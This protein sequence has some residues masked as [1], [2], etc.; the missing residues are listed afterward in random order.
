MLSLMRKAL[1]YFAHPLMTVSPRDLLL[2]EHLHP[3]QT[4]TALEIGVGSGSSLFQLAERVA[5]LHGV[6]IAEGPV[7]RLRKAIERTSGA[8]RRI[9]LFVLDYCESGAAQKLPQRYD[10]IYSCD[11]VE[12]V[13]SPA[14]FFENLHHALRPGGRAF[15]AFPN[16]HPRSA[17]GITFFEHR[18]TLVDL[19]RR[20]GFANTSITI[21]TLQ[22]TPA[23]RRV[24]Q[25][26]WYRP[27][28]LGKLVLA[29]ARKLARQPDRPSQSPPQTFDQTDFYS[30][31][32][33]LEPF[34]PIIN[35]YS[36]TLLRTASRARCVYEIRPA[37]D[38]LWDTT[39][40]I[41]V[42]RET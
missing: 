24:L 3:Q 39:V 19:L 5:Q 40:L 8:R 21:N 27:R 42:S 34:S 11:T 12:H 32:H 31:G 6:D 16:E 10:L 22:M 1:S 28:R 29:R 9:Q 30:M 14:A 4:D 36:W 23:A 38:V 18:Q 2:L 17:H 35:A 37:P 26:G 15:L 41:R 33:R 13:S 20:A 25:W 7:G